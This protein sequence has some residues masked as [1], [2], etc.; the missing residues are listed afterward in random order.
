VAGLPSQPPAGP[1]RPA[2]PVPGRLVVLSGPSGAARR[3]VAASVRRACPQIWRPV[4]VTTRPPGPG[5][6]DGREYLFVSAAEFDAM[7]SRDELL[8]WAQLG[9]NRYG[10]LRGP[11]AERLSA[12]LPTLAELDVDGARQLRRAMPSALL[13]FLV[14][15]AAGL[16]AGLEFDITLVN[17]S[18]EE[19]SSQL[20]ALMAAQPAQ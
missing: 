14:P 17:A 6:A 9:A 13:V 8:E 19:V 3:T 16:A 4:P 12:G 20:V 7:T 18:V 15:A 2:G 11:V 10:T 5:E 1:A